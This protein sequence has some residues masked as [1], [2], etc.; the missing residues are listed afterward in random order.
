MRAAG[1][2]WSGGVQRA[3]GFFAGGAD[4]REILKMTQRLA[5]M[6]KF[7]EGEERRAAAQ[8]F[9]R[10]VARG[11]YAALFSSQM[12]N[13]LGEE[14]KGYGLREEI[15]MMRVGMMRLLL[16]EESPSKMA[17]ALAKLSFA[18]G[19]SMQL[20][21][22]WDAAEA[23]AKKSKGF[24]EQYREQPESEPGGMFG[25]VEEM[26]R[27]DAETRARVTRPAMEEA[28]GE[29]EIA[30]EPLDWPTMANYLD[31]DDSSL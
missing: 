23:R 29:A 9:R 3:Q 11:D 12:V 28:G 30:F 25:V 18:L 2:G 4:D 21:A 14:G 7:E 15:G 24:L 26:M 10:Q 8:A 17:H 16:E 6:A 20:Q 13:A 19:K 5:E 1:G 22:G 31:N 27:V